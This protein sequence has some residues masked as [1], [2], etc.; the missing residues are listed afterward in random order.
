MLNVDLAEYF[1]ERMDYWG[2]DG[3]QI[4]SLGATIT[5]ARN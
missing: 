1:K 3:E 4:S 5:E 2:R